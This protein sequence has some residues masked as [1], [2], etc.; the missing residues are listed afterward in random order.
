MRKCLAIGG[1]VAAG[2]ALAT[3]TPANAFAPVQTEI[4]TAASDMT[5]TI[6][7]K[8]RKSARAARLK[9]R[10]Q[11]RLAGRT[12]A[13][14]SVAEPG[15]RASHQARAKAGGTQFPRSG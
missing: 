6:E 15:N 3:F 8:R 11:G 1:L 9:S 2:V 14:G 10:S 12:R 5:N 4:A 7:V 13:R